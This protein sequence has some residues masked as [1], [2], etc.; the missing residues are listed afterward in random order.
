M[1]QK[2]RVP[3]YHFLS[4]TEVVGVSNHN[5]GLFPRICIKVRGKEEEHAM[6]CNDER[7]SH[8]AIGG[9]NANMT[10]PW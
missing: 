7:G 1:C 4:L 10:E 5:G 8:D 2:V 9:F 3:R 6:G